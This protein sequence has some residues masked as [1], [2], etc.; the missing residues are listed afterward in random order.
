MPIP[1]RHD[2]ARP[3]RRIGLRL[4]VAILATAIPIALVGFPGS[5]ESAPR[6]RTWTVDQVRGTEQQNRTGLPGNGSRGRPF[7]T[8][9]DCAAQARPGDVCEI[10]DG[11]YRETVRP[12]RSGSP[13]SPITFRKAPRAKK[14]VISGADPVTGWERDAENP[15]LWSA[16]ADLAPGYDATVDPDNTTLAANQIF[17]DGTALPEAQFPNTGLD[18]MEPTFAKVSAVTTGGAEGTFTARSLPSGLG[19]LTGASI[20]FFGGWT[21][22][23]GEVTANDGQAISYA[24]PPADPPLYPQAG[25]DYSNVN[26][27]LIGKRAFL[28]AEH[29]WFYDAAAKRLSMITDG[30]APARIE[31][32]QRNYAVDLAGRTDIELTGLS[33]NAATVR[34]DD[35]SARIKITGLDARYVS[36]FMTAQYDDSLP[37]HG[38][39]DAAHKM[40]TGIILRGRDNTLADSRI[41]LST[42]S[43]VAVSGSGHTVTNNLIT[44]IAYGGYY[45]AP[46]TVQG[47]SSNLT[48]TRNTMYGAGRD[49]IN[50]NSN[51]PELQS[52]TDSEIAY[53]DIS[54]YAVTQ[55]DLGGLYVCCTVDMTDTRVSY[56]RIHDPATAGV[57]IYIDNYS[58]NPLIDHNV[59]DS[60]P[61]PALMLNGG[62]NYRIFNNTVVDA[63]DMWFTYRITDLTGTV[64]RNNVL[65]SKIDAA[66]PNGTFDHNLTGAPSQ[67][68]VDADGDDFR[69]A[70]NSPARGACVAIPGIARPDSGP[71]DLG[72]YEGDDAWTAGCDRARP[73]CDSADAPDYTG[74]VIT[75]DPE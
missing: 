52:L 44:D 5:A 68:W 72:A 32:K 41:A 38:A 69:L 29:E 28:D 57:G 39:Y 71:A 73:G 50:V 8:I 64:A 55:S 67:T 47:G 36:H 62:K 24:L 45:T 14:V 61:S 6:G 33:I 13:G 30:T 23:S 34:T 46:V 31:A 59:V 3:R 20:T 18:P 15:R 51:V 53:N 75:P 2:V 21:A 19:D 37:Y 9:A 4:A 22:L 65:T 60:G 27:R 16:P 43:G 74:A 56:N 1:P 58:F 49:G 70:P 54:A 25:G 17:A 48:I 12:A 10:G 35:D 40:D 11:T 66:Q 63:G 42:G 7:A 26:F